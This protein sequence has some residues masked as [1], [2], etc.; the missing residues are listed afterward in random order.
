VRWMLVVGC[1]FLFSLSAPAGE[2]YQSVMQELT[3]HDH[4]LPGSAAYT[5]SL[6]H[7]DRTL[8]SAGLETH[9]QTYDTLVPE[10]RECRLTVNG[11]DVTP[12][13]GLGPNG[14]A[15]NTTG[16]KVLAGPLVYLGSGT[17]AEMKG[18]PVDGC[19]A[20]LDFASPN[21]LQVLS[22]GA[23]A[24]VFVGDGTE[25]QWQVRKQF[26]QQAV[27]IPR[28]YVTQADAERSGLLSNAAGRKAEVA[29]TTVWKDVQGVNLWAEI[30]G[31]TG[32]T[33]KFDQEEAIV[34]TAT[35]DTFG[36]VPELSPSVRTAANC[37]LLAEVAA[38]LKAQPLKRSVFVVFLGSHFAAQ[39]GARMFYFAMRRGKSGELD[40]RVKDYETMLE[41]SEERMTVLAA[42]DF[43]AQKSPLMG[44]LI[45]RVEKRLNARVSILNYEL[46]MVREALLPLRRMK[47][48]LPVDQVTMDGLLADEARIQSRRSALNGMRRQFNDRVVT[49]KVLFAE[50]ASQEI[51]TVEREIQDVRNLITHNTTHRELAARLCAK[52]LM[53]HFDVDL[54]NAT[55]AW[56]LN[57]EGTGSQMF[58][59]SMNAKWAELKLGDYVKNI[60]S[61]AALDASL[62][63]RGSPGA[64]LFVEPV[65]SLVFPGKFCAPSIRS[66]ASRVAHAMQVYGYQLL[67]VADPLNGD[68]MPYRQVVDL[69]PL[70]PRLTAFT[71]ALATDPALSQV[72]P[73]AEA[74]SHKGAVMHFKGE[75]G[76]RFLQFARGSTT[77]LD[78]VPE[79]GIAYCAP[80]KSELAPVI[81]GHSYAAASRMRASGHI[82]MPILYNHVKFTPFAYQ[83]DGQ[84]KCFP[85]GVNWAD[86]R[87][88]FG[89]G[90]MLN[91]PLIP[92][93]FEPVLGTIASGETDE[94]LKGFRQTGNGFAAFYTDEE[95]FFKVYAKSGLLLLGSTDTK[96][97][98]GGISLNEGPLYSFNVL[99]QTAHDYLLLNESRLQILRDKNIVND[100]LESLH[101]NAEEHWDAAVAAREEQAVGSA[102]AH[103]AF[104][105]GISSRVAPALREV[106][107]DMVRAVVLLLLLILPFAFIMER[108]F[109]SATSIYR[110]V[111][112]FVAFF[113]GSFVLLYFVH[114]AFQVATSPLIIFLAFVIILLSGMV[115][116]I[117]M[118]KFKKELRAMQGLSTSAHGVASDSS[119]GLA[120]VLIGISG[121]RNR[122]L[123]TFLTGLTIILLTFAI[124]VFASFTPSTGV[125]S[126]YAGKGNGP[127]RIELHR[128]SGLEMPGMLHEALTALYADDWSTFARE[129]YFRG[130]KSTAEGDL[131]IAYAEKNRKWQRLQGMAAFDP[132]EMAHNKAI[133]KALPG[134]ASHSGALPPLYL[135]ATVTKAMELVPGDTVRIGG[136]AFAFA[137]VLDASA[138]DQLEYLDRSRI[139]PPDFEASENE[140]GQS[141]AEGTGADALADDAYVDTTRFTFCSAR[142]VGVTWTGVLSE[143]DGPNQPTRLNGIVMYAGDGADVDT[144][145]EQ[146]AEMFVGPVMA[147]SAEGAHKF[148]FSNSL[149]ATGF[150]VIIVPLLLG[151]LIIFNS[152]LG[153]I[154]EREKEIFTYSAMGLS[155]PSVGALFFAESGVYAIMGGMGGYLVSQVVAK[156]V[157]VCGEMGWFVPPEMNFSSL[158]SVMTSFVVM[159]MVMISTIYPAIK[160]GRSANPGV[161]RKWKM[162]APEAGK[163]DF[164]FPF[165]VS[166]DD[167][168]GILAFVNEHFE[169]H[170]D[171]SLGSFA[172]TNVDLFRQDDGEGMGLRAHVSLA[173]FDLGVMQEFTMFSRPSEIEDIDEIV[174]Q[175][176]KVSGTDGAWLR[177]NRVF[178]NDLREQFLLWRSLPLSTVMHYR[179]QSEKV[180]A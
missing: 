28:L 69:E 176:D 109:I 142:T 140:M 22:Q 31:E 30:P 121:M 99:R 34:L 20:V 36:T 144:T 23:R 85:R 78:G 118:S 10:T 175:L 111:V 44:E 24:I 84:L 172:A 147:K 146:V 158:S 49:N 145:A 40:Q 100:S 102:V 148:F 64:G 110:Q 93:G 164:V 91:M 112:G 54:A 162:P 51:A 9:R 131:L 149:Q 62:E 35:Y 170:G 152:L 166:A 141:T 82:F 27:E 4:R 143:L 72:C 101:A 103:E 14:P 67:T 57:M 37:A 139:M 125:T 177:G 7:L 18:Q 132:A 130:P 178:V 98:G 133:A 11:I 47:T 114:P 25:T 134:F 124:V 138:L 53:A 71:A 174:V 55:G 119:T 117:V 96:P 83:P 94:M 65:T 163:I 155:P 38:E 92:G 70:T 1:S 63:G 104:S 167:M 126:E 89:K 12:V 159:G 154:V 156:G 73:L 79:D 129:S 48:V 26:V 86:P 88:F 116:G 180:E 45:S 41:T 120:A 66:K 127:N 2:V 122:P 113:I 108:L 15:N 137:G 3:R 59:H 179:E 150:S 171:A 74:T 29:I 16:G 56:T 52:R 115:I 21:M 106:T 8:Q 32:A 76:L 97:R 168:G 80:N 169:N 58:Y 151:G 136:K 43:F 50:I 68:E 128:F 46:R 173:P 42:E 39:D 95:D 107:N 160:A 33:F 105:A 60:V 77:E 75:G 87:L 161:A 157:S 61:L 135:A 153:S 165:T 19:I 123:K 17:L 90:G 5:A 6:D 81:A 13:Y